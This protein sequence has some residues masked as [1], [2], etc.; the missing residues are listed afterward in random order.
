M[1]A[2]K[3]LDLLVEFSASNSDKLLR[4]LRPL[5]ASVPAFATLPTEKRYQARMDFCPSVES[6]RVS[7]VQDAAALRQTS[8]LRDHPRS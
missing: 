4:A 7:D 6:P 2:A 3:D 1:R 5:N 8:K